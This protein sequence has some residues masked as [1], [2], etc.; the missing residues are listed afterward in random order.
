MVTEE[1]PLGV[2]AAATAMHSTQHAR[3]AACAAVSSLSTAHFLATR[4]RTDTLAITCKGPLPLMAQ[5]F[6]PW[7][8][9]AC[10]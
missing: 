10:S 3:P 4:A 8:E 7:P 9:Q 6:W 5:A 2:A 1:T